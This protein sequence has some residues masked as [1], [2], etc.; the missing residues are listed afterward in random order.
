MVLPLGQP[1]ALV[2]ESEPR[3]PSGSH[4]R[5]T[6]P[7]LLA[8]RFQSVERVIPYD[9][10]SSHCVCDL[11]RANLVGDATLANLRIIRKVNAS[12]A[13]VSLPVLSLSPLGL[14]RSPRHLPQLCISP[15][16]EMCMHEIRRALCLKFFT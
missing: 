13:L 11:G 3:N 16:W 15:T 7:A 4:P 12:C 2:G 1:L 8:C 14:L 5:D 6:D 10:G 9:L